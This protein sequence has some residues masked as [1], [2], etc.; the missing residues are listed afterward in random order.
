MLNG[1]RRG[2]WGGTSGALSASR[3]TTNP[4]DSGGKT[5]PGTREK[6]MLGSCMAAKRDD[7]NQN[8]YLQPP[9]PNPEPLPSTRLLS[10]EYKKI[11]IQKLN[12]GLF[13]VFFPLNIQECERQNTEGKQKQNQSEQ[14]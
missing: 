14:E 3:P 4:S 9:P 13:S 7:Q 1:S 11:I 12:P 5:R 2:V 6:A 10:K 8:Q